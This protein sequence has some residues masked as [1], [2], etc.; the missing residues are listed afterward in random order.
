MAELLPREPEVAVMVARTLSG[1]SPEPM[2]EDVRRALAFVDGQLASVVLSGL[3]ARQERR[4]TARAMRDALSA[5]VAN[6]GENLARA[7]RGEL[8]IPVTDGPA[9]L[10]SASPL[11]PRR[12]VRSVGTAVSR[13]V[14]LVVAGSATFLLQGAPAAFALGGLRWSGQ[15]SG[16]VVALALVAPK[17]AGVLARGRSAGSRLAFARG[18]A[19]LVLLSALVLCLASRMAFVPPERAQ[20][21]FAAVFATF[22]AAWCPMVLDFATLAVPAIVQE[23]RRRLAAK[24]GTATP[25]EGAP[26]VPAGIRPHAPTGIRADVPARTTP[27]SS[28][29][30]GPQAS[31]SSAEDNSR[32]P[33]PLGEKDQDGTRPTGGDDR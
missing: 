14:W 10:D 11:S 27:A 19:V 1:L 28:A 8:L 7:L 2:P 17:V 15:L 21:A 4:P 16:A 13:A 24:G 33:A 25:V 9:W 26:H 22:A 3:S 6:Y 23:M 32:A 30:D 12:M 31:A 5:F 18:S 20:G 29:E